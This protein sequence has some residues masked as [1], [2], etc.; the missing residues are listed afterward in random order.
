MQAPQPPSPHDTWVLGA[1]VPPHLGAGE[2]GHLPDVLGEAVAGVLAK[3]HAVLHP[4]DGEGDLVHRETLQPLSP[5]TVGPSQV[6]LAT[7]Y[8]RLYFSP[9]VS[10]DK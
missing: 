1:G 2:V 4:I 8:L 6:K 3:A 9:R 10:K 5:G 7:A